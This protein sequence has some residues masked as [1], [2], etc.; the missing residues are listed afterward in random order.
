MTQSAPTPDRAHDILQGMRG[1]PLDSLFSPQSVALVGATDHAGSVGHALVEALRQGDRPVFWVNPKRKELAGGIC[2]PSLGAIPHPIDLAVIATPAAGV[3]GVIRE[4]VEKGVRSAI[5]I[6]AGFRE[7][8][9]AGSAL[10]Q[11]ILKAARGKGLRVLGPNCLGVMVPPSKLNATF[12]GGLA[13]SGHVAFLSQSGALCSAV[14]DWSRKTRVGFSAFVSVGAMLDVDWGDLITY[15]GDDPHTRSILCYMESAG[16]ARKLLSAAREVALSKPIIVLK[17]G[18]TAAASK[19]AASHTG[20]LTGSDDVFD[21]ALRRVGVLRVETIEELFGMAEVLGKQKLPAGPRLAVVTNAGGA[22]ALATD[23][24]IS[25]GGRLAEL[26]PNTIKS[27]DSFLPAHWSHGNPVDVLGDADAARFRRA[28]EEVAKDPNTD[29]LLVILTPQA[30]TQARE[31][32]LAIRSIESFQGK[33][34][35]ASWMGAGA[36]EE[37][38]RLLEEG[39]IPTFEFPDLAARAFSQMWNYRDRLQQLYQTPAQTAQGTLPEETHTNIDAILQGALSHQRTLLAEQE[40]RELLKS[41][42]MPF[43]PALIAHTE[44]EAVAQAACLGSRVAIKLHSL[45]LTHKSDVGGVRLGVLGEKGVRQAWR[46][47][48]DSVTR[49]AGRE[50]FQGVSVQPMVDLEGVELI[51]GSTTDPQF[52]PVVLFGAGGHWVEVQKDTVLGLPPLNEN[53]ARRMIESTRIHQALL[54]ARGG[55][56]VDM[57]AL[58]EVLVRF[59]N[60]VLATPR[61]AEV[62]INPLLVAGRRI[63]ALDA[64]VVLHPPTLPDAQ[65]PKPAIRAYPDQYFQRVAPF[66]GRETVLRAIR[67]EDE[68]AMIAFHRTLSERSVYLRYFAPLS[69]DERIAHQRLS[70]LCFIDYDR[71][72]ALVAEQ[73][74][75]TCEPAKILGVGRLSKVHGRN[76][77]EFALLVSDTA[78]HCGLGKALLKGLIRIGREEH[79]ERITAPI[80][81]DN[82]IMIHLARSLG[83]EVHHPTGS[84]ECIAE[85]RL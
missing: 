50:H 66:G 30:M 9:P 34:I 48:Y 5:V 47:I 28:T 7:T 79:L 71:E 3:P 62:E 11:E 17:V 74:G 55:Q 22:G 52:G 82:R 15:L 69:L 32:A 53:L 42:G 35:L 41:W 49:L 1:N 64:R 39:S 27:L 67:P 73:K 68:P 26:D 78:Q 75:T 51:L 25:S 85:L 61:I 43:L 54:G 84:L 20:S 4:C 80:L 8:G 70:R 29:G 6:S 2:Y 33:P 31:T 19:A 63:L 57:G 36:V 24:L 60:G 40:S 76:E 16:D 65:L 56:P 72:I 14:L 18:R 59:A 44:D 10:E 83:F 45:T 77:G 46:E 38:R 37:G 21:A 58:S 12:A 81:P 13:E 23:M